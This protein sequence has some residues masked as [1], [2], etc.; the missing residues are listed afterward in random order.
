LPLVKAV[1]LGVRLGIKKT[2]AGAVR[3]A[4]KPVHFGGKLPLNEMGRNRCMGSLGVATF[5]YSQSDD[6]LD[7]LSLFYLY[8]KQ[9]CPTHHLRVKGRNN[10]QTVKMDNALQ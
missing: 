8:K 9:L 5:F 3:L 7:S 1:E 10:K 4:L 6:F 2:V